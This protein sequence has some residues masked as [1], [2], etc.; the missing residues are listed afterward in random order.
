MVWSLS[1]SSLLSPF[2]AYLS[3]ASLYYHH[4]LFLP[5]IAYCLLYISILSFGGIM[6]AYLSSSLVA[7][8]AYLLAIGR[9]AAAL[10]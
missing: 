5:S 7:L 4:P 6:T 2:R 9:G 8:P 3:A 1:S 10:T